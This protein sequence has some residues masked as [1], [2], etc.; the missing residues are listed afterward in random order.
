PDDIGEHGKAQ[1]PEH[2]EAQHH[3]CDGR[4]RPG[5]TDQCSRVHYF[6]SFGS[7]QLGAAAESDMGNEKRRFKNRA[8]KKPN[9]AALKSK[10]FRRPRWRE[11]AKTLAADKALYRLRF[12]WP[13]P[14]PSPPRP[15]AAAV[16]C[17][18]AATD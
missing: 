3:Q 12:P 14:A 9:E 13:A 4:R 18:V 15:S 5:R 7:R 6:R 16:L 11:I 2:H 1:R 17:P 10:T 8:G